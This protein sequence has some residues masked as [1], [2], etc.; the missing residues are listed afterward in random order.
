MRHSLIHELVVGIHVSFPY[1]DVGMQS[2]GILY[3]DNRR[4]VG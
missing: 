1:H 3:D 2:V 4:R